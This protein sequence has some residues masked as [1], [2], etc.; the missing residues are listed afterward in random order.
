MFKY[1][2]ALIALISFTD[3]YANVNYNPST[4]IYTVDQYGA[5]PTKQIKT[6]SLDNYKKIK[7]I[8]PRNPHPLDEGL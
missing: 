4:G 2:L 7:S 3:S 1:L 6:Q 8:T 5:L